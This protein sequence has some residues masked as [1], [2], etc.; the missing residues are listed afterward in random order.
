[1]KEQ[2][3]L[4]QREFVLRMVRERVCR[5]L[6]LAFVLPVVLAL[7]G[8]ALAAGS[9]YTV[10]FSAAHPTTTNATAA[11]FMIL[12]GCIV[13]QHTASFRIRKCVRKER[14]TG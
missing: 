12:P 11:A 3:F 9:D 2:R 10:D 6:F 4:R 5:T 13:S 7:G 14:L 1:M 8:L